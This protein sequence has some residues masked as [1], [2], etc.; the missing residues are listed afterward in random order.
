MLTPGSERVCLVHNDKLLRLASDR[1]LAAAELRVNTRLDN[2][3]RGFVS[4]AWYSDDDG[5]TWYRSDNDVNLLEQGIE[6]QEPHLVELRDGRVMMLF[7]TYSGYVGR[8]DSGD[9]GQT[10]SKGQIVEAR[11]RV[12]RG[13][14]IDRKPERG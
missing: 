5:H 3:H 14:A 4:T 10:W 1:I 6:S 2:D 9:R 12:R 13:T 7:R 11:F 8:A